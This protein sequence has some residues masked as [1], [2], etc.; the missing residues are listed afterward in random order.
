MQSGE[1]DKWNIFVRNY[2]VKTFNQQKRLEMTETDL[3][4]G[5]KK[6]ELNNRA[7]AS[8]TYHH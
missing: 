1:E 7:G 3:W 6:I 4:G 5:S 2:F 8:Q